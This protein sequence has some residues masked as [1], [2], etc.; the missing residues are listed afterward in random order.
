VI[1]AV[2]GT[3]ITA[4]Y[5][6]G[7]LNLI[8][9]FASL[10][11]CLTLLVNYWLAKTASQPLLQLRKT[12]EQAQE[13]QTAL[14]ETV[15]MR[16]DPDVHQ[17]VEAINSMLARLDLRTR[18]L[19]ALSE[20]AIYAQEEERKRIAR[21]L[22][23]ETAQS[24]STL[25]IHVERLENQLPGDALDLRS[26]LADERRLAIQ[27]LDNLRE[28]IW[29]L[30]PAILDD[31]GLIPAIRWYARAH[32]EKAGIQVKLAEPGE[33]LHLPSH[34]ETMLFR[35]TQEAVS[36]ILRHSTPGWSPSA[37]S[38][39]SRNLPGGRGRWVRL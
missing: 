17:L 9:L 28:N 36:N 38:K 13:G 11:I 32:L 31:L 35:V 19:R 7:D 10:G 16:S 12:V 20:R 22:H 23:D 39:S 2:C 25:I 21:G 4:S 27:M 6:I 24:I 15:P 5:L 37:C 1:G 26:R 30:R 33:K 18:Q 14:P 8:L 34:L 3:I 29:D